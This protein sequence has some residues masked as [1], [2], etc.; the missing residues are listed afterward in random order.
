MPYKFRRLPSTICPVYGHELK[1]LPN[2]VMFCE[3]CRYE[4]DRDLVPIQWAVKRIF[5][6]E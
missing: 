6:I 1:Q 2:R 3:K 5:T 4:A